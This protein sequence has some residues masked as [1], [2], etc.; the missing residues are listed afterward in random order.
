MT[1]EI[2]MRQRFDDSRLIS[3][4]SR[5]HYGAVAA[6]NSAADTPYNLDVQ[7]SASYRPRFAIE[8]AIA[9]RN[10]DA[11]LNKINISLAKLTNGGTL[12]AIFT[13]YETSIRRK[14][15][16]RRYAYLITSS[17]REQNACWFAKHC[18]HPADRQSV[19][20]SRHCQAGRI[21]RAG[22]REFRSTEKSAS[23]NR[24]YVSPAQFQLILAS[25]GGLMM[26]ADPCIDPTVQTNTYLI[27]AIRWR[28]ATMFSCF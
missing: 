23:K 9:A 1:Y 2:G 6:A 7:M 11:L 3:L 15:P 24:A 16:G 26:D 17:A 18:S 13:K 21:N 19:A 8:R 25:R 14:G 4:A 20:E 28:M 5:R 27:S 10:G 12:K 22:H